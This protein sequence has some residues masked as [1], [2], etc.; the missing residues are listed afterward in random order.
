[1]V[2]GFC[3]SKRSL[4]SW[5]PFVSPSL[6][7]QNANVRV[8]DTRLFEAFDPAGPPAATGPGVEAHAAR[9]AAV[10]APKAPASAVL[11]VI[12]VEPMRPRFRLGES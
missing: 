2:P 11:L 6:P 5:K 12:V 4:T 8:P 9:P 7:P 3:A 1:M 10:T